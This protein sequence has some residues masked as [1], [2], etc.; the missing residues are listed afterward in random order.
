[1]ISITL[2]ILIAISAA[3]FVGTAVGLIMRYLRPSAQ[4]NSVDEGV[5]Q[6]LHI[7]SEQ[8]RATLDVAACGLVADTA[9]QINQITVVATELHQHIDDSEKNFS[10]TVKLATVASLQLKKL[11]TIMEAFHESTKEERESLFREFA[12]RSKEYERFVHEMNGVTMS[13]A[14]VKDRLI[15]SVESSIATQQSLEMTIKENELKVKQLTQQLQEAV[16]QP[17]V[18][19]EAVYQLEIEQ[20]NIRSEYKQLVATNAQL[21]T[22]VGQLLSELLSMKEVKQNQDR[23]IRTLE[24]ENRV[25]TA[26]INFLQ[27]SSDAEPMIESKMFG[28]TMFGTR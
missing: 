28:V 6:K 21:K 15:T 8:R 17:I 14:S 18:D 2:A 9:N 4:F 22:Q 25:L 20:L 19:H 5:L 24:E 1:M 13:L 12:L 3:A 27:C 10:S 23:I 11:I 16:S 26:K 7:E